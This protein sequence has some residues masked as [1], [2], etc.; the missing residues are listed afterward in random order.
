VRIPRDIYGAD[1]VKALRVLGY[2]FV[3]RD[4][5]HIRLTTKVN[6]EHH[7]TIPDHKPLKTGTLVKGV[8]KP[9][10]AHHKITVEELLE[11]LGLKAGTCYPSSDTIRKRSP[12]SFSIKCATSSAKSI[13]PDLFR[14]RTSFLEPHA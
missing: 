5:S 7:V 1:L 2:E 4:S 11:K 6:G 13:A 10:A 9:V 8:L 14:W 12:P 3:R